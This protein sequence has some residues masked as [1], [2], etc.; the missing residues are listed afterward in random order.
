M[1]DRSEQPVKDPPEGADGVERQFAAAL[2]AAAESLLGWSAEAVLAGVDEGTSKDFLASL[3][4]PSGCM[5]LHRAGR[6]SE[7]I[8]WVAVPS[9]LARPV[10]DR[11]LGA[12]PEDSPLSPGPLTDVEREL[13]RRWI[14]QAAAPLSAGRDSPLPPRPLQP[15]DAV[16]VFRLAVKLDRHTGTI[17]LCTAAA[18]LRAGAAARPAGGERL[19]LIELSAD[20]AEAAEAGD[21]LSALAPG[22]ILTTD[23]DAGGP[24]PRVTVRLAGIAKFLARLHAC[25]GKRAVTL[26]DRLG[27]T[28]PSEQPPAN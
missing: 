17:R 10:A 20:V 22:D 5:A 24:S 11:M 21:E 6:E 8:G 7:P 27:E 2:V 4:D 28:A 9:Q 12:P 15:D 23:L 26:T 3:D 18:V 16:A 14:G 19:G 1:A 13:V 25:E